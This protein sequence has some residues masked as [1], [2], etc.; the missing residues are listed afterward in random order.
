MN[1]CLMIA[2]QKFPVYSEYEITPGDKK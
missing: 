1:I 2:E